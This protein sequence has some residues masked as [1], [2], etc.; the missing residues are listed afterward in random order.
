MPIVFCPKC[1]HIFETRAKDLEAQCGRCGFTFVPIKGFASPI[2]EEIGERRGGMYRCSKGDM[3]KILDVTR[4]L[5][6]KRKKDGI[7][8]PEE[9]EIYAVEYYFPKHGRNY[10]IADG[11]DKALYNKAREAFYRRVKEFGLKKSLV[12]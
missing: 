11:H 9:A 5:L 12:K 1:G 4:R 6:Y 7:W 10:K 2:D 8:Y 3:H